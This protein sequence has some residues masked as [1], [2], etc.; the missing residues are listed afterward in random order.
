MSIAA[1]LSGSWVGYIDSVA[2]LVA[3]SVELVLRGTR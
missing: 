2:E 3:C 1:W